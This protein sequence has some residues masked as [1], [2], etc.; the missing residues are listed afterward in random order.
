[1]FMISHHNYI[2]QLTQTMFS[3]M[4]ELQVRKSSASSVINC[5][6]RV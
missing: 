4:Y 5:R 2:L 6:R 1:M 3:V